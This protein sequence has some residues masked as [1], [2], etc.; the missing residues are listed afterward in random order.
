M[1]FSDKDTYFNGVDEANTLQECFKN[2][3]NV[4]I[5]SRVAAILQETTGLEIRVA[6][7]GERK[8]FAGLLRVVDNYIQIHPDYAPYVSDAIY[9][10]THRY[11][12]HYML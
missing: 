12:T 9:D 11:H 7:E 10:S 3:A 8:Y 6:Q 5:L 2:E 1:V 4:D